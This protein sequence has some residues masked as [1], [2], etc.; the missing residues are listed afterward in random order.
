MITG[1]LS[2]PTF[3]TP[4]RQSPSAVICQ[5]NSVHL[6]WIKQAVFIRHDHT[7]KRDKGVEVSE[8]KVFLAFAHR[9]SEAAEIAL[10]G[11]DQSGK[12]QLLVQRFLSA[13]PEVYRR[14]LLLEGDTLTLREAVG[15]VRSLMS[16]DNAREM[17]P[18]V[19]S[20]TPVSAIVPDE[21]RMVRLEQ[22]VDELSKMLATMSQ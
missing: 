9:L 22:K 1:V 14:H 19:A 11:L 8:E 13:I 17:N 12:D 21:T 6:Q 5:E 3:A 10:P 16:F 7:K 4:F 18:N 15:E 20:V 2:D